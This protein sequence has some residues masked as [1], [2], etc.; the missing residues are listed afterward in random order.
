[1]C[2]KI[3]LL[4]FIFLLFNC[5]NTTISTKVAL[6]KINETVYASGKIESDNQYQVFSLTSGYIKSINMEEGEKV[7]KNQTIIELENDGS[8]IALKSA[9]LN[10][11]FTDISQNKNK[12]KELKF[13]LNTA[14]SKWINDSIQLKRRQNLLGNNIISQSEFENFEII[15]TTSKSN[16]TSLILQL[17]DLTKQLKLNDQ[18]GKRNYDQSSKMVKDFKIKSDIDG[19]VYSILKKSG[20][21]VTPQMPIAIIGGYKNYLLK[22]QVDEYDITKIKLGQLIKVKLD[23]YKGKVFEAIV[24]K[25]SPFMNEKTKT[26]TIEG[27][28]VNQPEVLYPNLTLEANIIINTNPKALLIPR[29]YLFDDHFVFLKNGTTKRVKTGIMDLK[30]VEITTGLKRNTEIIIPDEN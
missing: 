6:K 20:E 28:F 11:N 16:Y 1:M 23:S 24:T 4:S 17:E 30:Y 5:T 9:E 8:I 13:A 3:I 27:K 25:I 26:F 14:K 18:L 2:K 7:S 21:L 15:A 19:V 22:L 10:R 29:E 12:I